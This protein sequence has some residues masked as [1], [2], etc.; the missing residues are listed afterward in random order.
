MPNGACPKPTTETGLPVVLVVEDDALVRLC[1]AEHLREAGYSVMEAMNGDE[2]LS[3]F[4]SLPVD[5]LFSDI[6]MPGSIDGAL[7]ARWTREHCPS[8]HVILTSAWFPRGPAREGLDE[9]TFVPKP[10]QPELVAD[11]IRA[12]LEKDPAEMIVRR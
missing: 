1:I 2:A 12:E 4:A 10:Y 11:L 6:L 9:V 5:V 7:L 8:T 3:I